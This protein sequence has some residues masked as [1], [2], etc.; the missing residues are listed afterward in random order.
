ML[1]TSIQADLV[2][3]FTASLSTLTDGQKKW[4]TKLSSAGL[5]YHHFG[6][7]IISQLLGN[8]QSDTVNII[9]D[10]VSIYKFFV[11]KCAVMSVVTHKPELQF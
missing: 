1:H 3:S 7:R 11:I 6:H 2:R 4:Q 5:I 8:S 10:K 9:Y